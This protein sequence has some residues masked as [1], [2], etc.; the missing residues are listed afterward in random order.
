MYALGELPF[1]FFLFC[2]GFLFMYGILGHLCPF[3]F[4]KMYLKLSLCL[5]VEDHFNKF[6]G[7][8]C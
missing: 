4:H 5:Y 2:K 1:F 7:L 6:F 8:S 3:E